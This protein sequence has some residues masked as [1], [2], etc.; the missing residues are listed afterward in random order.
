MKHER[1]YNAHN[2]NTKESNLLTQTKVTIEL[3]GTMMVN[4]DLGF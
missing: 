3:C 4:L 1:N 2:D